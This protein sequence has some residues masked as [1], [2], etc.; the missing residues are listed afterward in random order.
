MNK[1]KSGYC[2]GCDH[3]STKAGDY[4][5]PLCLVCRVETKDSS[6]GKMT[7]IYVKTPAEKDLKF[8]RAVNKI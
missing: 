7:L 1:V 2:A 6:D 4:G 3:V 5:V 8:I